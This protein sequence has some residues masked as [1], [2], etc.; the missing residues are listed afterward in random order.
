M[1]SSIVSMALTLVLLIAFGPIVSLGGVLAGD[2]TMTFAIFSLTKAW[3][4]RHA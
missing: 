1:R 3:K 2:I 4:A